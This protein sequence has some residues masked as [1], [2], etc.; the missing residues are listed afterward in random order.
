MTIPREN[1]IVETKK[2]YWYALGSNMPIRYSISWKATG[3]TL[4]PAQTIEEASRLHAEII[5]CKQEELTAYMTR[6]G[7]S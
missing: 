2:I 7:K 6:E 5:D 3:A 4:M 1:F